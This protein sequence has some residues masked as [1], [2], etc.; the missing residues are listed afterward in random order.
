[1]L[2]QTRL[3]EIFYGHYRIKYTFHKQEFLGGVGNSKISLTSEVYEKK[4]ENLEI[5]CKVVLNTQ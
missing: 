2:A 3:F 1:M 4:P 5:N